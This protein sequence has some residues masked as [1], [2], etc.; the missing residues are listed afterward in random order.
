M[1]ES[2]KE[3]G[4][5]EGIEEGILIGKQE[6]ILIGTRKGMLIGEILMAQR[7]LKQSAYSQESLESKTVDELKIILSKIE[8]KLN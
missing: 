7:I 5:E 3:V 4:I 6:G 1:L 2:I 8:A